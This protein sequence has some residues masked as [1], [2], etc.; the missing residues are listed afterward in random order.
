MPFSDLFGHQTHTD[1]QANSSYT[2]K[3]KKN[4]MNLAEYL[5]TLGLKDWSELFCD[6]FSSSVFLLFLLVFWEPGSYHVALTVLE[7]TM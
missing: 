2:L 1:M 3:K 4:Q 6:F 7:H 5:S